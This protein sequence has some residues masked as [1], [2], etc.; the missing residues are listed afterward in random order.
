MHTSNI[1]EGY[2]NIFLDVNDRYLQKQA[3][4][5]RKDYKNKEITQHRKTLAHLA[6]Y[7][8]EWFTWTTNNRLSQVDSVMSEKL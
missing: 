2:K 6:L 8:T 1:K 4:E 3:E 5:N 7:I